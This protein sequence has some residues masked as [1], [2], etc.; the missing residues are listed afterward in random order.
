MDRPS[1]FTV[2]YG[3]ADANFTFDG[4]FLGHNDRAVVLCGDV[5]FDDPVN[6]QSTGELDVPVNT[7]GCADQCVDPI[8][9]L[10]WFFAEHGP[11]LDVCQHPLSLFRVAKA[12]LSTSPYDT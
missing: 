2:N 3:V 1:D 8:I 5:A 12:I 6:A 4:R 7:G 11:S 10:C 9:G